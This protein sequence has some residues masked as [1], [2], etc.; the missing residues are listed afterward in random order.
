MTRNTFFKAVMMAIF[1]MATVGTYAQNREMHFSNGCM[2]MENAGRMEK[3]HDAPRYDDHRYDAPRHHDRRYDAPRYNAYRHGAYHHE[4]RR[5][6][7]DAPRPVH[8]VTVVHHAAP[9][10][11][12]YGYLPGWEGRVRYVDGRYGY[13]RGRDWYWYDTYYEP[14]YYYAHPVGHFHHVHLTRTG[15]AVVTAAAGAAIL[16]GILSVLA[17]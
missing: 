4:A 10:F 6:Y 12:R 2:R 11:D 5:G 17:D 13:L 7:Y 1:T 3:R 9:R 16:G 8:H 14:A 15:R